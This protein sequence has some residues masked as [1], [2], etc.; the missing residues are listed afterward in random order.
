MYV[1]WLSL[2]ALFIGHRANGSLYADEALLYD[3][4]P[5]GFIW[6]SATSAYQIEGAWDADGSIETVLYVARLFL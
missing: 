4:F 1:K 3:K 5:D 2:L 6:A